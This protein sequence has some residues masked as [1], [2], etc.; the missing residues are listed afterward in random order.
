MI[1]SG[2][3]PYLTA[4]IAQCYIYRRR[5][6]AWP[7]IY[8]LLKIATPTFTWPEAVHPLTGGGC[9]GDG[10]HGWSA[11]EFLLLVRNLLI[12]EEEDRIVLTPILPQEWTWEG[13]VVQVERAP[14]YFGPMGF[15][16]EFRKDTVLLDIE[17]QFWERPSGFEW[18]LPFDIQSVEGDGGGIEVRGNQLFLPAES[19][20]VQIR[21]RAKSGVL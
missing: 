17:E 18:N 10:H 12:F 9:M 7:L 1:H 8:Y 6:E 4:Q 20:T 14:T 5:R 15:R 16:I 21:T 3:N 11:A 2:V 19:R 13:A